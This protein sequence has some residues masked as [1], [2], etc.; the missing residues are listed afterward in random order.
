[1][2]NVQW[3]QMEQSYTSGFW[4]SHL[5]SA[6]VSI[7]TES[8]SQPSPWNKH[9]YFTNKEFST[10]KEDARRY[11][12]HLSAQKLGLKLVLPPA[13]WRGQR[14]RQCS[15]TSCSAGKSPPHCDALYATVLVHRVPQQFLRIWTMAVNAHLSGREAEIHLTMSIQH[16][17]ITFLPRSFFKFWPTLVKE[18]APDHDFIRGYNI[19]MPLGRQMSSSSFY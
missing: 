17:Q 5:T 3:F 18:G 6:K 1:M 2:S 7:T 19:L 8:A 4:K 9:H 16:T 14:T 13:F 15:I 11:F 10:P 12:H